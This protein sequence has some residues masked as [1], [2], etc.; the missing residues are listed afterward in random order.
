MHGSV[1]AAGGRGSAASAC[2]CAPGCCTCSSPPLA[3]A[4]ACASASRP[5]AGD[6]RRTWVC[7]CLAHTASGASN[8]ARPTSACAR[9]EKALRRIGGVVFSGGDYERWDL[10]VRGGMLGSMRLRVAVE[11]HGAG[12]QLVRIRS[13]PRF[14][15]IGAGGGAR[16]RGARRGSGVRRR[17]GRPRRPRRSG[18]ADPRVH[19]PGLRD[20]CR[21]PAHRAHRGDRACAPRA[22]RR[23]EEP[24]ARPE[25]RLAGNTF[26][27]PSRSHAERR[28][29]ERVSNGSRREATAPR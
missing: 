4:G 6:R 14:S 2:A 13:W 3:S 27:P 24:T 15:R 17:M 11:E 26:T 23:A 20:R 16:V 12:R 25:P 10:Y 8:G 18:A 28:A 5:G 19:G 22:R 1:A 7:R 9:L 21:R 29:G